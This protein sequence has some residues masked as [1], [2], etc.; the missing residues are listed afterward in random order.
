MNLQKTF[1]KNENQAVF[2]FVSITIV[3]HFVVLWLLGI[4]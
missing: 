2:I 1:E 4:I 3:F